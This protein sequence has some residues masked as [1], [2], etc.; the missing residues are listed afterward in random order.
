MTPRA[1]SADTATIMAKGRRPKY[2]MRP[3]TVDE[4]A[5]VTQ[6][7]GLIY[8]YMRDHPMEHVDEDEAFSA[9]Q[10]AMMK[11]AISFE[12][13]R[14]L[15]F[16]TWV[17]HNLRIVRCHLARPNRSAYCR[18]E[19]TKSDDELWKFL[20]KPSPD[21]DRVDDADSIR[22]LRWALERMPAE[23]ALIIR[24]HL[25]SGKRLPELGE[26][27]G[28]TRQCIKQR[29]DKALP[30]LCALLWHARKAPAA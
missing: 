2:E 14:G 12:P 17:Y 25:G 21:L 6:N 20:G 16:S 19:T 15:K 24:A 5:L 22:R 10:L 28:V 23:D 26:L 9:Y 1:T 27:F 18:H 30:Q 7:M 4:Q 13:A 3:L 29:I 8:S 11:A